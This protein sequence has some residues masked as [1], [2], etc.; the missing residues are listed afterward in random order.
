[1]TA[2]YDARGSTLAL[3]AIENRP[4]LSIIV[5][6]LDEAADIE[7]ALAVLQPLRAAGHE[8]IVVDGGSGDRTLEIA[9]PLVDAALA[10]PR[11]RAHQMN[12]GAA[13]AHGDVLLFLHADTRLPDDAVQAIARALGAGRPWGRFDVT[14][15]GVSPMLPWVA[16]MMNQRSRF[17]GI[18]T[19]DH[20]MFAT[21]ELFEAAGGFPPMPLMEDVAFSKTLR[22]LA[23]RPACLAER[24]V[25]SGRRW[26][27]HGA[28]RTIAMMWQLRF[29]YWRGIDPS[30]LA[31]RYAARPA[32]R[33]PVLQV[34]AKDP[35]P[36]A[37]KTRLAATIGSAAAAH[38]YGEL[39]ERTLRVAVAARAAGV[40]CDVELWCEPDERRP[41]FAAWR[42]QY[43]LTL[44]TQSDGDLGARMHRALA[45]SLARGT[46]ALLIGTDCPVLDVRYLERAAKSLDD[47]DVVLGPAEDGGYVLVGLAR[48]VDVFSGVAWSTP[49]V[50]AATRAKLEALGV[51]WRELPPLWDLDTPDDLARY[52]H[53]PHSASRTSAAKMRPRASPKPTR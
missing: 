13:A 37:V 30:A 8:V 2:P 4:R 52:R 19:G 53:R 14:I 16:T 24:V 7:A 3:V 50:M 42:A 39:V 51:A 11:G 27:R 10:A 9:I 35:V 18:A 46:P 12:A 1:M 49:D 17:T 5:P 15:A 26:D 28:W 34:F 29:D 40:V 20:A 32:R 31:R 22:R 48:D 33:L 43:R 21:R 45:S 25:T 44:Q 38:L 41:A 6:V 36:G 23:G 47:G